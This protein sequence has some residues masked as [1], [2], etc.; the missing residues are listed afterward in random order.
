MSSTPRLVT[1]R[2]FEPNHRWATT[3]SSSASSSSRTSAVILDLLLHQPEP[4]E[5]ARSQREQVGQLADAREAAPPEHLLGV[6]PLELRQIE[7]HRLRGAGEVVHAEER[8]ALV[9]PDVGEDAL[10]CGPHRLVAPEP[11]H[12]VLL[13]QR[14]EAVRPA[15]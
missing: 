1:S 3:H 9:A 7:L 8:L 6:A 2:A 11:E 13:A 4:V 10:V 12:R 15:Q 14:D 5:A